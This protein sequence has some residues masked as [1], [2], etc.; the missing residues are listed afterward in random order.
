MK[1]HN[2][3]IHIFLIIALLLCAA[4]AM[5]QDAAKDPIPREAQKSDAPVKPEDSTVK[6]ETK[7]K[8]DAS[9]DAAAKTEPKAAAKDDAAKSVTRPS[10]DKDKA[11]VAEK[12]ASTKAKDAPVKTD[13]SKDAAK[14]VTRPS[15]EK[16]KS[17][18]VDKKVPATKAKDASMNTDAAKDAVKSSP[19]KKDEGA[20]PAVKVEKAK[21]TAA[22]AKTDPKKALPE[23]KPEAKP[24]P[25]RETLSAA[26]AKKDEPKETSAP[27]RDDAPR[28]SYGL[29]AGDSAFANTVFFMGYGMFT[30][31]SSYSEVYGNSWAYSGGIE[32]RGI[33]F[34]GISPLAQAGYASLR[35]KDDPGRISSTLSLTQVL[36]GLGWHY[37]CGLPGFMNSW[38]VSAPLELSLRAADGVTR[39]RFTSELQKSPV[40]E[41][42]HTFEI[43][44]QAAYPVVRGVY[45]GI[46]AGYRFVST[47][48]SPLQGMS[49]GFAVGVRL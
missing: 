40:E 3:H 18:V 14:S 46:N 15:P 5:S 24:E 30:P 28:A 19:V 22:P 2:T 10:P 33:S 8:A 23:K 36:L 42:I 49:A 48:G 17:T 44:A 9:K 43:S 37:D 13:P 34:L 1:T 27:V 45:V 38:G 31:L 7:A 11:P 21:E 4:P 12:A 47:A 29:L 35:S 32:L 39:T 25:K 41:Y 6:P 16:D 20:K 26:L